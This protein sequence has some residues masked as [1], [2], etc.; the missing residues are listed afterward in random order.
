MPAS[1]P[2]VKNLDLQHAALTDK[3]AAAERAIASCAMEEDQMNSMYDPA[4]NAMVMPHFK[5]EA[6]RLLDRRELP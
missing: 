6:K 2:M 5:A 1:R 3:N 4:M